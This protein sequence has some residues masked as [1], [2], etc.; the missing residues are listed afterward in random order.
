M[1]LNKKCVTC[2]K[3]IGYSLDLITNKCITI[4]GDGIKADSE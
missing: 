1:T 3:K 2:D 4:C